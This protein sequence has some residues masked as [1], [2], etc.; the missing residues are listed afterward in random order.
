MFHV[1]HH[2]YVLPIHH[3]GFIPDQ[4]RDKREWG[5]MHGGIVQSTTSSCDTHTH[6]HAHAHAH[7]HTHTH[8]L[9]LSLF[10]SGDCCSHYSTRTQP[11]W[12]CLLQPKAA[13][14]TLFTR[15][16]IV[17]VGD[18]TERCVSATLLLL[19][20]SKCPLFLNLPPP[21]LFPLLPFPVL[22]LQCKP[23]DSWER[24][25]TRS[26]P[27]LPVNQIALITRQMLEVR[28]HMCVCVCVCVC[29]SVCVCVCVCVCACLCVSVCLCVCVCV[30]LCVSL[31]PFGATVNSTVNAFVCFVLG[32]GV[33]ERKGHSA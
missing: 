18:S 3:M 27:A 28:V 32:S 15:F 10:H 21:L 13:S 29:H 2:P 25:Y 16:A 19:C 5:T 31:G 22:C 17:G 8:S 11:W 30:S 33:S 9:S 26:R 4:V 20:H 23:L 24:K 14:R 12:C 7:T 1:I 6:A